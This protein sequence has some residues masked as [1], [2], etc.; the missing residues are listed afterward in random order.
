MPSRLLA[1]GLVALASAGCGGNDPAVA[2]T[3][4]TA[5]AMSPSP[6]SDG[7]A[8][9]STTVPVAV[10]GT[11]STAPAPPEPSGANDALADGRHAGYL[12]GVD[13]GKRTVVVDVIQFLTGEAAVKAAAA[14]GRG[15]DVPNDYYIR[16]VNPRLRTLPLAASV[17]VT[18]LEVELGGNDAARS[19]TAD[20]AALARIVAHD[21]QASS[22]D[23]N[24]YWLTVAG[25]RVA[26][27]EQQYLP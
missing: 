23:A 12:R 7:S 24:P 13:E 27:V 19:V 16:N 11:S 10:S 26:K 6:S 1:V 15:S 20:V 2:P 5:D 14:D 3:T 4:T 18:V 8:E 17:E 25:G 22:T 9:P 21:V